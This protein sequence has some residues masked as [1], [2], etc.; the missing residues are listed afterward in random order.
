V[1]SRD[2]QTQLESALAECAR[3]RQEN[4]RLRRVLS[5]HDIALLASPGS[6]IASGSDMA[7]GDRNTVNHL[8]DPDVKVELFRSLFRGREDV[9]AV[10]W[11]SPNGRYGYM[12]KADRDWK[13]YSASKP[14]D[15]KKVDRKTR[16]FWPLTDEVIRQHLT[17]DLTIGIYPLLA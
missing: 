3:L 14:E 2:L 1:S 17:G 13:A 9:Y 10:R 4:D 11:E 8:S 16:K 7:K 5:E 15:R 6:A 12:P